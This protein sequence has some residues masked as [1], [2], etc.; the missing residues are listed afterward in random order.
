MATVDAESLTDS[1]AE[2]VWHQEQTNLTKLVDP[3]RQ[4]EDIA[5]MRGDFRPLSEE[6]GV[7]AKAFGFGEAG[8]IY[9]LH[10]PMAFEGQGAIWYQ[11]RRRG[12]KSVLRRDDAEVRR[13]RRASRA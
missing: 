4:A 12:A 7:L 10:C 8:P 13:S 6:I 3:L 1:A 9:E 2:T 11:D 5:A